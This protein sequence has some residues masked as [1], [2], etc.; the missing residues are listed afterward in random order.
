MAA[1][2][3]GQDVRS[4]LAAPERLLPFTVP[5]LIAGGD[6]SNS[7][8]GAFKAGT[9]HVRYRP[10]AATSPLSAGRLPCLAKDVAR[11]HVLIVAAF[12]A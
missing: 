1:T 11:G 12:G 8:A 10:A 3:L 2:L 9:C 6:G 4:L 7:P 5:V